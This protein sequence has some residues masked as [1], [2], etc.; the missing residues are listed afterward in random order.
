M[1]DMNRDIRK[2]EISSFAMNLGLQE[3]ILAAHPILLPP[4]TFKQGTREGRSPIDGIW[5]SANLQAS[6]VSYCP[7]SLSPG[8]HRAA[9]LDIDLVLLIGEPRFTVVRPK[10]RRLNTQLPQTKACYL[11]L[12]EEHF[13]SH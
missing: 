10:A 6:A 3:S 8:D 13:L 11:A 9:L 12:L 4:V 2:E 1:A 5:M 7:A